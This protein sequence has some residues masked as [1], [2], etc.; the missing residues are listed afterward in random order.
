MAGGYSIIRQAN[1]WSKLRIGQETFR[2]LISHLGVFASFVKA[3]QAFG[4]RTKE[5]NDTWD[6]F[7]WRRSGVG[8]HKRR[9]PFANLCI[10]NNVLT[11]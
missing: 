5:S 4:H 6:N 10:F 3:V 9:H 1:S 2:A 7:H 8:L 11:C